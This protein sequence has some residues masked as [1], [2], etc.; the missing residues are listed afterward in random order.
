TAS[1]SR[2]TPWLPPLPPGRRPAADTTPRERGSPGD[3]LPEAPRRGPTRPRRALRFGS[4]PGVRRPRGRSRTAAAPPQRPAAGAPDGGN[5]WGLR[6]RGLGARP[7]EL[8]WGGG[9][10]GMIVGARGTPGGCRSPAGGP[11]W[12]TRHVRVRVSDADLLAGL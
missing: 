5:R 12:G 4:P 8:G 10:R 1:A 7:R 3:T 11:E 2:A 6:R 9:S